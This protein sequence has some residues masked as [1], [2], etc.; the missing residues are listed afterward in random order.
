MHAAV[1]SGCDSGIG[2]EVSRQLVAAGFLVF[3]GCFTYQGIRAANKAAI[4]SMGTTKNPGS[5]IAVRLDISSGDSIKELRNLVKERC[6]DGIYCLINNAG[7]MVTAAAEWTSMDMYRKIMDVN[8]F[9][10]VEMTKCFLPLIRKYASLAKPNDLRPRIIFTSSASAFAG[11]P[12]L[13]AYAASKRA[14]EGFGQSLAEELLMFGIYVSM[15]EP[16]GVNTQVLKDMGASVYPNYVRQEDEIKNA[17]TRDY[18]VQLDNLGAMAIKP[19]NQQLLLNPSDVANKI[20]QLVNSKVPRLINMMG[21]TGLF[22]ILLT[23][24]GVHIKHWIFANV[25]GIYFGK[26]FARKFL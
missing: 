20:L 17:Y 4:E 25:L 3:A 18:A 10:H 5:L 8:Y 24:L 22:E 7:M 23:H 16:G 19:S 2:L 1:V 6:P 13:T 12:G 15:V 26:H 11:N 9:G 21:L 14:I